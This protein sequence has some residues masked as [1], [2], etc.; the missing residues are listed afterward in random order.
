MKKEPKYFV[1]V[2][3]NGHLYPNINYTTHDIFAKDMDGKYLYLG[4][5]WQGVDSL[6]YCSQIL[7]LKKVRIIDGEDAE[8]IKAVEDKIASLYE[9]RALI[10]KNV[11]KRKAKI[12]DFAE[13]KKW[14]K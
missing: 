7:D 5:N 2:Q 14:K 11:K 13:V 6:Y 12:E 8:K 3:K 4:I 10:I 9:E 1:K